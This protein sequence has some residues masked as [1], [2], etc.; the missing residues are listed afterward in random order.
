MLTR[1][2]DGAFDALAHCRSQAAVLLDCYR[3]G[4]EER[5]AVERLMSALEAV[6]RTFSQPASGPPPRSG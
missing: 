4:T 6:N 1:K 5:A 2:L 3:P